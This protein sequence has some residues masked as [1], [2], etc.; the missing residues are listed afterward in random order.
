MNRRASAGPPCMPAV[1]MPPMTISESNP[2][3]I[4][5]ALGAG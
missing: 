2:D 5:S 4:S 1:N 3:A